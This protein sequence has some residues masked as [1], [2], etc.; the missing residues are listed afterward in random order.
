MCFC[1]L[2]TFDVE[3]ACYVHRPWHRSCSSGIANGNR[4]VLANVTLGLHQKLI[5]SVQNMALHPRGR[6]L[7]CGNLQLCPYLCLHVLL[8][9]IP[10][11]NGVYPPM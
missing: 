5:C 9:D 6:W 11:D 4:C 7:F 2:Q 8:A 10:W 3:A 1:S